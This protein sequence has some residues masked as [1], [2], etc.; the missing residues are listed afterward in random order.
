MQTNKVPG[1]VDAEMRL[2]DT[3]RHPE[4]RHVQQD[5][6]G[7]GLGKFSRDARARKLIPRLMPLP[8]HQS[9]QWLIY[10]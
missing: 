8:H 7:T 2:A 1:Q 9:D 4:N 5:Y 3:L 10:R 6:V